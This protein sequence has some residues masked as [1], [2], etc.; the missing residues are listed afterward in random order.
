MKYFRKFFILRYAQYFQLEA[1]IIINNVDNWD[2]HD[3]DMIS[4]IIINSLMVSKDF[5]KIVSAT[6]ASIS[7]I[8]NNITL[9]LFVSERK[10]GEEFLFAGFR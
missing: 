10:K 6:S 5:F 4:T 1:H 9:E 3:P 8:G 7:G 2:I